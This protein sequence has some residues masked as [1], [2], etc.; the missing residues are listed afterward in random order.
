LP[1]IGG[2]QTYYKEINPNKLWDK[3]VKNAHASAEPGILFFD[4]IHSESPAAA[5]G[6]KWKEVSTNPCGEIPL[7]PFD[8]CRLMAINMLSYVVDPFLPEARFDDKLFMSHVKKAM[9]LMDDI[10]DLEIEKI[11]RILDKIIDGSQESMVEIGLWEKIRKTAVEGRRTGLGITA[12]GDMLAALNL[13]YGT[14]EATQMSELIHEVMA[15]AAFQ[16]S[17]ELAEERGAFPD[18]KYGDVEASAYL[19]RI[20]THPLMNEYRERYLS[21]GRR[22]IAMLTIAPTGSVSIMTQTSSGIEPIFAPYYFRK[23]KIMDQSSDVYDY[24]DEVGDKWEEFP[25]FHKTFVIE[26]AAK[27]GLPFDQAEGYLMGLDPLKLENV[28]RESAYYGATAQDVDYIEKARMQGAV[29]K[30]VDH[31][32]SVTVNM[33]STAT[34]ETVNEVYRTAYESGCKGVTVYVDGSRGSVL[35][36]ESIKDTV[37]KAEDFEYIAA[38][39][40][41]KELTCDIYHKTSRGDDYVILVGLLEGKPYEVFAVPNEGETKIGKT[42]IVGSIVKIKKGKYDLVGESGEPLISNISSYMMENEQNST[43]N[44]SAMLRHRMNPT[45]IVSTIKKY[46]TVSS[47]HKVIS[48]VIEGY[49]TEEVA[50]ECSECGSEMH[51]NE[52][53]MTCKNCGNA[54][55]G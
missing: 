25:V 11:D 1:T 3:I 15:I 46:A 4:K 20:T 29:Q 7:S 26:Y 42:H 49:V 37:G 2:V 21:T 44:I 48:K 24:K 32:I 19:K 16:S 38:V 28:Y 40:R 33:P 39:K 51:M 50:N 17:I 43:R 8:S 27:S 10:V 6:D 41:P 22:N 18:W 55:C 45:Y 5:Y 23:K 14:K 47:F 34:V 12:E 54:K 13:Q 36:I 30:W 35:N 52:G 31:S 9:R 53:C